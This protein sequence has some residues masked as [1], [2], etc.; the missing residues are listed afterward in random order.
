MN[1]RNV[2]MNLVVIGIVCCFSYQAL[3]CGFQAVGITKENSKAVEMALKSITSAV[4]FN[5]K[6]GTIHFLS[7][8]PVTL[9]Q[10]DAAFVKAGITS[11]IISPVHHKPANNVNG[12]SN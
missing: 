8:E 6:D 1:L 12:V 3:A 7:K 5:P 9:Q 4:E 10:I 2:K 11:V